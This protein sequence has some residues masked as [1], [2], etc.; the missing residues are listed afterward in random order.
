ME[1]FKCPVVKYLQDLC[2]SGMLGL[3]EDGLSYINLVA[4]AHCHGGY[5]TWSKNGNTIELSNDSGNYN[6]KIF[7][8]GTL[9]TLGTLV[10]C[11]FR[12]KPFMIL[13]I[14]MTIL[15]VISNNSMI[16]DLL[17]AIKSA[18]HLIMSLRVLEIVSKFVCYFVVTSI[19][20]IC[21]LIIVV[22]VGLPE[23]SRYF[24][25]PATI[26]VLVV[27]LSLFIYLYYYIIYAI[28]L[29]LRDCCQFIPVCI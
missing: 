4:S 14:S 7:I 18:H 28:V 21:I 20:F 9:V 22:L 29:T 15:Y 5:C 26:P 16:W 19:S 27:L 3:S 13:S 1:Y 8:A 23:Y 12:S 17:I 6:T 2:M 25:M 24:L 11:Y 10:T